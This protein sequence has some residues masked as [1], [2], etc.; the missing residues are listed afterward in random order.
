M[1]LLKSW[2]P[3]LTP[4]AT[5]VRPV[6]V[7]TQGSRFTLLFEAFAIDV[8]QA[9]CLRAKVGSYMEIHPQGTRCIYHLPIKS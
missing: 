2:N 5:I 1:D 6:G 8:L 7:L 9:A 3:R 4:E